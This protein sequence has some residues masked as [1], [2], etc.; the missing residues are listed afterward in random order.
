MSIFSRRSPRPLLSWKL[1]RGATRPRP[2]H[3]T[4]A[5]H[6]L[7]AL[8]DVF[9]APGATVVTPTGVS[10]RGGLPAGMAGLVMS[11]S[12]LAAK[13]GVHVLNAPGLI[14]P[15]YTG[16]LQVILHNAGRKGYRVKAGERIAQLVV[17]KVEATGRGNTTSRGEK[18]LGSTGKTTVTTPSKSADG[19]ADMVNHPPHYTDHPTF[20]GEAWIFSRHMSFPLGNAFKYLWRH[21]HKE[22][23]LEDLQKAKW[24]LQRSGSYTP[25]QGT[26]H[27]LVKLRSEAQRGLETANRICE[28]M[29]TTPAALRE[30]ATQSNNEKAAL[31]AV[32]ANRAYKAAA[33]IA[34]G[35]ESWSEAEF[36]LEQAIWLLS[37]IKD[38]S[39]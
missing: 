36:L 38:T 23:S 11:R 13:H 30:K 16:E 18:G 32:A 14:D 15:G 17:V 29:G 37:G 4:D 10:I 33:I 24:Y 21:A 7:H 28:E 35:G 19:G 34:S 6:D 8:K 25:P 3:P 9:I 27:L 5:G 39:H 26:E 2:A 12:G 1:A 31:R 20:S 22:N